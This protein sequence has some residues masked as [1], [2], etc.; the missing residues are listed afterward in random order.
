MDLFARI[1]V[2]STEERAEAEV[3]PIVSAWTC[4][5]VYGQVQ[6][7]TECLLAGPENAGIS[8]TYYVV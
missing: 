6:R 8:L 5:V 4:Y 2:E 3:R 1:F 7:S